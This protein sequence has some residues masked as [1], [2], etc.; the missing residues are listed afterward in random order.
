MW[1]FN[2]NAMDCDTAFLS[3]LEVGN[4]RFNAS[5]AAKTISSAIYVRKNS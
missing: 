4:K 5:L 1:I 3:D 2:I